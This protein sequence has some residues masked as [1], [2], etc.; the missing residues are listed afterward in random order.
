MRSLWLDWP[1]SRQI[2][3]NARD[4]EVSKPTKPGFGGFVSSPAS[5]FCITRAGERGLP[6]NDPYAERM[7]AA[8]R[9]MAV[10]SYREGMILWLEAAR[11][12]LYAELIAYIPDEISRL[13]NER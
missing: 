13:W 8:L 12:Q 4:D 2:I 11:P 3:E 5:S 10:R 6:V 7:G 1:N 9:Q